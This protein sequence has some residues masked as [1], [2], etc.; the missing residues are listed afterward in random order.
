MSAQCSRL[1]RTEPPLRAKAAGR[2]CHG[3]TFAASILFGSKPLHCEECRW[4]SGDA[5]ELA[6]MDAA[7]E[8]GAAIMLEVS[9]TSKGEKALAEEGSAPWK[10][11]VSQSEVM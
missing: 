8:E 1:S 10:S 2:F 11:L 3:S 4:V 5:R 9:A 6:A 7:G